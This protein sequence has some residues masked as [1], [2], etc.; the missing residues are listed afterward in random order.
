MKKIFSL[1]ILLFFLL[2]V[3]LNSKEP[4]SISIPLNVIHDSFEKYPISRDAEFTV[5][6]EVESKNIFGQKVR[7]LLEEKIT[8][9]VKR[10]NCLL[11]SAPLEINEGQ[12]FNVILDT[13][14]VNLWVPIVGSK[15]KYN[16]TN[17]YYPSNS[18]TKTVTTDTFEVQYGTGSTKGV[19]YKDQCIF[20]NNIIYLKFGVASETNFDV[21]GADG[22][23]GLA[24]KYTYSED[25]AIWRLASM[26][27]ISSRSFSFKYYSDSDVRMF[28]GDEHE[29]FK[30]ENKTSTCQLL[31]KTTY[32]NLVWTCKLYSFGFFSKS[33][34]K[35]TNATCGYN[36]LFDTGSNTM[37]L[38][39]ETLEK[40]KNDLPNYDCYSAEGK[41]G[42]QILCRNITTMPIPFIEVGDYAL[43]LD[44]ED[45]IYGIKKN[46][47][48]KIEY[49]FTYRI[50]F[51][52]T[53]TMPLI[54]QPFFKIFHTKF[55]FE[56]KV[57]KFYS[58]NEDLRQFT[59]VKPDND[60]ARDFEPIGSN[61]LND[62]MFYILA[63]VA[64]VV[65][66]LFALCVLW[67]CCKAIFCCGSK[68][69][70]V[71]KQNELAKL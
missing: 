35:T 10:L 2:F 65:A 50:L 57:L 13:G 28:L 69:H 24:K 15:D 46:N 45:L 16:I 70:K 17:H 39:L 3:S 59:W 27:K 51:L 30:D 42:Y 19:Y 36:F 25:S 4:S 66:L 38:P 33:N 37:R 20:F 11:F 1:S 49:L 8:G 23:M 43:Y 53:V 54:G 32:D 31:H 63:S 47:T 7:R 6:K 61:W 52:E 68:H 26:G 40:I 29:D 9:T 64:V 60:E 12:K 48:D 56:G 34:N 67:K 41:D 22:I 44:D 71:S 62:H 55:D 58:K 18:T 14:S 5:V 21:K